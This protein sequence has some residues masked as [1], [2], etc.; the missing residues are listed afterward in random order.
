MKNN[1]IPFQPPAP[2]KAEYEKLL[3]AVAIA[4]EQTGYLF[5]QEEVLYEILRPYSKGWVA[6]W[7]ECFERRTQAD[8]LKM[9]ERF[10]GGT[11]DLQGFRDEEEGLLCQEAAIEFGCAWRFADYR[12]RDIRRGGTGLGC[13]NSILSE[14]ANAYIPDLFPNLL[15]APPERK[16]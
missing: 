14:Y 6:T 7:Q 4:M 16:K 3:P 2:E 9:F 8:Y 15:P 1:V 5:S 13:L 12:D 11:F 10:N